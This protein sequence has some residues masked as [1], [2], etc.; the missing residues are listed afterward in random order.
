MLDAI[1]IWPHVLPRDINA[2]LR[3][4]SWL[5]YYNTGV[6]LSM[7]G[8]RTEQDHPLKQE[9]KEDY[10]TLTELHYFANVGYGDYAASPMCGGAPVLIGGRIAGIHLGK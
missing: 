8:V 3:V 1:L 7:L 2:M 9:Y 4:E 5:L 6:R 10:G